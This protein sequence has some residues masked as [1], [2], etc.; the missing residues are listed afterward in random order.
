MVIAD[1]I[2]LPNRTEDGHLI[3]Y[4]VEGIIK[5]IGP[6]V[7]VFTFQPDMATTPFGYASKLHIMME[8]PI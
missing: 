8:D 4:R 2:A 3:D 6:M 5:L 1:S 7:K